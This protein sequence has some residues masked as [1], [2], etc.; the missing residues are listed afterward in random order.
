M[1]AEVH[2]QARDHNGPE[3]NGQR[4]LVVRRLMQYFRHANVSR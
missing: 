2:D 4:K 1:Q 3:A